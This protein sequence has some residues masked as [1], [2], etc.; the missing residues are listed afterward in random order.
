M[1]KDFLANESL[2]TMFFLI[3]HYCPICITE[4]DLIEME[5]FVFI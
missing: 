5:T 4:N 2:E 3:K 1:L